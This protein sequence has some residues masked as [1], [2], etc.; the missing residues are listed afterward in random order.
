[1]RGAHASLWSR[2]CRERVGKEKEVATEATYG[3]RRLA[4]DE[5]YI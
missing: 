2:P 1:M 5:K 4:K 3:T